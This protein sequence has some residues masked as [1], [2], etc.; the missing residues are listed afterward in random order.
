MTA[1]RVTLPPGSGVD[2]SVTGTPGPA[3]HERSAQADST[4]IPEMECS[5][6][7]MAYNEEANVANVIDSILKQDLTAK[8]I[9]EVIV[10]ASGCR[11]RT[12][13][14][15][16]GI[17]SRERRVRLI[18][19]AHREGKASA[20]NLFIGAARAP[21]LVMVSA[22][23][24]VEDGA[25]DVLL[26][27]FADP[28][29]GMVGGHPVPV[30]GTGTFLGHAVHLQ[31]HLHDRIARRSPKL[32]EMVAFRNV[33]PSIPID[34]AVD[35][36]SIQ[37]LITQL[38]YRLVYEP[39]AIVY[40]RGP[41]TVQDFLRQRRRIYAG[42]LRVREQQAYSAPT[43]S[44]WRAG[45]ALLGSE[46]FSTPQAALWSAGTVGLEAAARALGFYD[47]VRGHRSHHVWEMCDTTKKQIQDAAAA[48]HQHNVA[49]FRIVDF[50][51][52]EIEI[53]HHASRQ[54][55]RRVADRMQQA[56]GPVAAVSPQRAGTIVALL[57]GDRDAAELAASAL[58]QLFEVTRVPL[59]GRGATTSISLA[60]G[61]I[62]F[63]P[64]GP[65][66]SSA[67]PPLELDPAPSIVT[68]EVHP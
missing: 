40:N 41:A 48:Q 55:A 46:S 38:G 7:V 21:V 59:N 43:M 26:R 39:Q 63:P 3:G 60:Y 51:R 45:C 62:A 57:P 58:V 52:L 34:T 11:D 10:V 54:L 5:V 44:A 16:A 37:A 29:V 9:R 56:L 6:G 50:R 1:E 4:I 30:N 36:L 28:A 2:T 35:E 53:G 64:S 68:Q 32:G 8:R 66:L 27:H 23:V 47:I 13:D 49:V 31:W 24:I 15:V 20:I 25:F 67:V 22:D 17:A 33:V 18:E 61:I 42:H 12:V 19:Q 65:P 14:I